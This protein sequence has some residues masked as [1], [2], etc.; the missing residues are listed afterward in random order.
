M[1]GTKSAEYRDLEHESSSRLLEHDSRR[2]LGRYEEAAY[3]ALQAGTG[4]DRMGRL[5][6]Q[7]GEFA[8]AAED[9]LSAVACFLLATAN[10]QAAGV[11][12]LLRRLEADGKIPAERSD[13]VGTLRG[14]EREWKDLNERIQQFLRDFGRQGHQLDVADQSTLRFLLRHVRDLP[15][16]AS[17]HYAIFRQATALGQEELAD[18][19]LAWAATFDPGNPNLAAWLGYRHLA[20]GRRDDAVRWASEF[21]AAHPSEAGPVRIM[22]ASALTGGPETETGSQER[23]LEVLRP[24][25]EDAAA[26]VRQRSAA[27]ALTGALQ[28]ELG[29]EQEFHRLVRELEYLE[30]SIPVAELRVVV[31]ELRRLMSDAAVNGTGGP[32]AL[33]PR[34]RP[35]ADRLQLLQKAQRLSVGAP[36]VVPE[37]AAD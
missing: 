22:L 15:G 34:P 2:V 27:L 19:H 16:L 7:A 29:R 36:A 11:L 17:L 33:P 3:H 5:C 20:H 8:E 6:F 24:L 28:R 30:G 23:A 10:Q 12:E 1:T 25:V 37:V 26:D 13:L 14:R 9:W 32:T 4:R 21:L 31:A 35:A 18:R